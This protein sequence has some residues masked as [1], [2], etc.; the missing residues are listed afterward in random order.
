MQFK[1]SLVAASL[2]ATL[3]L[4]GCNDDS[5]SETP[6]ETKAITAIDGYLVNAKVSVD[7]DNDN[8]CDKELGKTI[9]NGKFNLPKQYES[10]KLCIEA[11]A[12]ETQ[13]EDRGLVMTAFSL[14]APAGSDVVTPLTNLVAQSMA[15]DSDLSLEDAQTKVIETLKNGGL[16]VSKEDVFGDYVA[17]KNNEG[18]ALVSSQLLVIA[19]SLTDHNDKTLEQQ[20]TITQELSNE[21]HNKTVEELNDFAPTITVDSET[22]T[23]TVKPNQRPQ[24]VDNASIKS[25]SIKQGESIAPI[26]LTNLFSDDTSAELKYSLESIGTSINTLSIQN[27]EIVGSINVAGTFSFQVFATDEDNARSKPITFS[28]TVEGNEQPEPEL[29]PNFEGKTWYVIETG[30]SNGTTS[31]TYP[32]TWCDSI[33]L[34]NGIVYYNQRSDENRNSCS[35]ANEE[36]GTYTVKD[37]TFTLSFTENSETE[38]LT[39]NVVNQKIKLENSEIVTLSEKDNTERYTYFENKADAEKRLNV[40]SDGAADV[41]D[42]PTVLPTMSDA[43]Y[44]LGSYSVQMYQDGETNKVKLWLDSQNGFSCAD[45]GEFYQYFVLTSSTFGDK[46]RVYSKVPNSNIFMCT[47]SKENNISTAVIDFTIPFAL[48]VNE[49]YSLIG[50]VFDRDKEALESVKLNLIWTGQSNND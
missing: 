29:Q 32:Q 42:I 25:Q 7:T 16:S 24:I 11:I 17:S 18:K 31:T 36:S 43:M 22:G 5:S 44:Q 12:K 49:N 26:A 27:N 14:H 47:D 6:V 15:K 38:T 13:D 2:L 21:V 37:N 28:V 23:V 34:E 35:E 4:T 46:G 40:K 39:L 20:L 48:K 30:S 50:S 33:R 3:T 41:R 9:A 8:Q 1:L 45:A 10:N 19:E